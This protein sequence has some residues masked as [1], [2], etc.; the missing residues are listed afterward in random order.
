M[1]SLTQRPHM[2]AFAIEAK[3]SSMRVVLGASLAVSVLAVPIGG[4][5]LAVLSAGPSF[6][7]SPVVPAISPRPGAEG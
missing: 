4:P 3:S 6:V 1:A 2:I 5:A 7:S